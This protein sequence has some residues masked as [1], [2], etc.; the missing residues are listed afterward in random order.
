MMMSLLLTRKLIFK[1]AEKISVN[2]L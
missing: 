2:V 1:N